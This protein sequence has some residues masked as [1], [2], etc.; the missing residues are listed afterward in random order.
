MP[1]KKPLLLH[2]PNL[3][4]RNQLHKNHLG[5]LADLGS[6]NG[7]WDDGGKI[8][9]CVLKDGFLFRI[10]HTYIRF[11]LDD[12]EAPVQTIAYDDNDKEWAV[13]GLGGSSALFASSVIQ[14]PSIREAHDCLVLLHE[15]VLGS[16]KA[17]TRDELFEI[18]D[19]VA[20]E[21]LEGDRCAVFLPTP[22]GWTLW[23]PHERRLR[24]RFGS[25]PF[26]GTLLR[27][28]RKTQEPLLCT[29]DGDLAPSSSMMQAGVRSAMAA[30]IRIGEELQALIYIDRLDGEKSFGR[31]HLEFLHAVANQL[32]VRLYNC[33]HVAELEAEVTRLQQDDIQKIQ[34]IGDDPC[35]Q[36]VHTFISKAAPTNA[37]VLIMGASGTGK[38]LV[39]RSIHQHSKRADNVL[40]VVNCA[41]IAE[42]L[43]E[44]VLFGHVKGAFTG[45][46]D[47]RPGLFELADKGTL[48]LDELGE[49]PMS[50][51]AKLLRA[52]EQGEVQRIGEG[53]VRHVDVRIIAATNR[54]LADEVTNGNFREDLYHRLD[55]L[56]VQLPPLSDRPKDIDA[57][58]D[59][60][61]Q[62]SAQRLG[63]P[64]KGISPEARALLLRYNWPGNVRQL[65]NTIERLSILG[66][67]NNIEASDIPESIS[68]AENSNFNSPIAPLAE[69]ER[70]H[71]MRVLEHC[72][73]NK[74]ATA[75]MLEI[76]RST[77]Y[78][79]LRQYKVI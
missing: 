33:D 45:A 75:E 29:G 30:P 7:L 60:F 25:T 71:I 6:S 64:A 39:A 44:S 13:K 42:T 52:L 43:V 37:P 19:D 47:S 54:A 49:L 57:L 40:Q 10:G 59:Y 2:N 68:G 21:S 3:I 48:F 67:S 55:V 9:Q 12:T 15:V 8:E 22:D 35:M 14:D 76:D 23:P 61:L 51:Q 58:I 62:E 27:E 63:E 56:T 31:V 5:L 34:I 16:H 32:A 17:K 41:A 74:K 36:P 11:D 26:A 18:L 73:G 66:S 70:M 53:S 79:K 20:A 46:D 72:G 78:A 24:A 65:R 28:V 1:L 4:S 77:L 69:I 50:A 38:E